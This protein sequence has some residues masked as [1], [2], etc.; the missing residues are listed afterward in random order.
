MP[1]ETR[2]KNNEIAW[3]NIGDFRNVL[4]HDYFGINYEILWNIIVDYLPGQYNF[5]RELLNDH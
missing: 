5:L 4:I 3:R 2:L 1:E